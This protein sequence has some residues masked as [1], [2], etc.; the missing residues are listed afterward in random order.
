MVLYSST[1]MLLNQCGAN[2]MPARYTWQK[3]PVQMPIL[4]FGMVIL[5]IIVFFSAL[6]L[7]MILWMFGRKGFYKGNGS[8]EYDA[9]AFEKAY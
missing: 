5:L 9:H 1:S 6:P 7:Q 2:K 3:K 4:K 8:W